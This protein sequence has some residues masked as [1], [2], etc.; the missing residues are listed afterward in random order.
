MIVHQLIKSSAT[1]C[2]LIALW[3]CQGPQGTSQEASPSI[4]RGPFSVLL[5]TLDTTRADHLE[6]YGGPAGATPALT[7]LAQQG[8]VMERAYAVSPIT[9]PTHASLMTGL[10]PPQHGVRSNGRHRLAAESVTLAEQLH[11]HGFRTAA[12]LSAA[13]LERRYGLDQ[14]FE[15]YD[16]TLGQGKT[17][18]ARMI[19][20][21]LGGATVDMAWQWLD[22]LTDDQP[23][24]LWVHLFDPHASYAPPAPFDDRFPE[25]PYLGEI[26][27]MDGEIGRLLSHPKLS[28]EQPVV[29]AAIA[30]H[31]ESLGEHGEA[32]HGLLAYD[33]T[34][35]IPWFMRLPEGP[36]GLRYGEPVSQVDLLPTLLDLQGF[37]SSGPASAG[38]SLLP[39]WQ[40]QTSPT[41]D[42]YAESLDPLFL[43]GWEPLATL[44]R[45]PWKYIA[46]PSPELYNLDDDPSESSNRHGAH[47]EIVAELAQQLEIFNES[48]ATVDNRLVLD[49]ESRAKLASLGYT[50]TSGAAMAATADR[51]D[52]KTMIDLHHTMQQVEGLIAEGSAATAQTLLRDILRRDPRNHQGLLHASRLYFADGDLPSAVAV[53][54]QML[55]YY[56]GDSAAGLSLAGLEARRG[57]FDRAIELSESALQSD[58]QQLE[59]WLL[60]AQYLQ[61]AGRGNEVAALYDRAVVHLPGDPELHARMG[62]LLAEQDDPRA[63]DNARAETLARQGQVAEA[64]AIWQRLTRDTP[65]DAVPFGNLAA[66]ALQRQDWS[67]AESLAR[68]A[69]ELDPGLAPSWNA[70]AFALEE[71][72]RPQ[73]AANAYR[74]AVEADPTYTTAQLN[75]GLLLKR[76]QAYP[77]A[78]EVFTA[79]LRSEPD[80]WNI[81][82][83]LILLYAGPLGQPDLARPHLLRN[84]EAAPNH[85]KAPL[86]REL[87]ARLEE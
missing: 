33:A 45:A 20:E 17:E 11:S 32:T 75:L 57:N 5:L 1:F 44:R 34:L 60:L 46:A 64:E 81:H 2:C 23:F 9:L 37:E 13:V 30:D 69:V 70:L 14:G 67:A 10:Y 87:L 41:R 7:R 31:G 8:I 22:D 27:Y 76:Q 61:Q 26:A 80:N 52:P 63:D 68:Q 73:Q 78:V 16:D 82:Y 35:Q 79:L 83:E 4:A 36:R 43:Y 42:L 28:A 55:G 38:H 62:R 72:G 74:R 50:A 71:L 58:P 85:P 49:A 25:Q 24:F 18:E 48:S 56:P 6:P 53:L 77:Q 40:G 51:P 66:L 12:F 47:Q 65:D 29:V 86:L 15:V 54:E 19:S 3:G 59:P 39:F 84:L 21:R